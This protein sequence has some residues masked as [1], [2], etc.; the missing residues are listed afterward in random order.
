ME[1]GGAPLFKV[2]GG[3]RSGNRQ[4]QKWSKAGEVLSTDENVGALGTD[5]SGVTNVE[6]I[7]ACAKLRIKALKASMAEGMSPC[8]VRVARRVGEE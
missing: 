3:E 8:E 2:Q 6:K 7:Q 1:E 5:M 4:K